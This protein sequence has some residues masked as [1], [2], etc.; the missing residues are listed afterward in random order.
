[1]NHAWHVHN[2]LWATIYYK[3][4]MRGGGGGLQI[5][6]FPS[7]VQIR[8]QSD[9]ALV[10]LSNP[11]SV[12][13]VTIDQIW[14]TQDLSK[15]RRMLVKAIFFPKKQLLYL[16]ENCQ[17]RSFATFILKLS[18]LQTFMLRCP[19][20]KKSKNLVLPPLTLKNWSKNRP[21]S[22]GLSSITGSV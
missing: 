12:K 20:E 5:D 2:G 15:K 14:T 1:M 4:T 13:R 9:Q 6:I 11:N 16:W 3:G 10:L 19:Y 18:T 21:C 7:A 17:K 8:I 22:E